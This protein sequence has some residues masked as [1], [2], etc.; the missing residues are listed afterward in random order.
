MEPARDRVQ[1]NVALHQVQH[2]LR[3]RS[4]KPVFVAG[5]ARVFAE[6]QVMQI[7]GELEMIAQRR[8]TRGGESRSAGDEPVTSEVRP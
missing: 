5:I 8:R 1:P 4:I 6:E 2:V 3:S 7:L